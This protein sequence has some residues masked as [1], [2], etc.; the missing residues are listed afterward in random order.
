MPTEKENLESRMF[1]KRLAN[2]YSK[3][4]LQV[5]YFSKPDV[6]QEILNLSS[7]KRNQKSWRSSQGTKTQHK[8]LG[9][10]INPPY[11]QLF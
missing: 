4:S 7:K 8:S 2:F 10:R 9:I 6:K 11:Q 3:S 5:E 1:S